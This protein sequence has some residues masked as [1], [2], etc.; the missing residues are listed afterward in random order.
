MINS[1]RERSFSKISVKL[2]RKKK[3][4]ENDER[5]MDPRRDEKTC[6]DYRR[7]LPARQSVNSIVNRR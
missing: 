1:S 3:K 7:R 6:K 4:K 2:N 5:V